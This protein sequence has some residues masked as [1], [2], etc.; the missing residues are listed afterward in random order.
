MQ[1][2]DDVK[3]IRL[4]GSEL[5][6]M[7]IEINPTG[8]KIRVRMGHGILSRDTFHEVYISFMNIKIITS[9]EKPG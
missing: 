7:L 6:G 3:V 1:K 9:M 8:I 4:D 5:R 2:G